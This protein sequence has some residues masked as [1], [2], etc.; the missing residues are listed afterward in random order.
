MTSPSYVNSGTFLNWTGASSASPALPA[1]RVTGNLLIA[2]FWISPGTA[3]TPWSLSGTGWNIGESY[4]GASGTNSFG[5]MWAWRYVDGTEASPTGGTGGSG[6][7]AGAIIY[8]YTNVHQTSPFG[9]LPTLPSTTFGGSGNLHALTTSTS[10]SLVVGLVGYL[11]NFTISS[12]PGGSWSLDESTHTN[13]SGYAGV[14]EVSAVYPTAGTAIGTQTISFS[15]STY[16]CSYDL[17]ILAPPPPI[18]TATIISTLKSVAQSAATTVIEPISSTIVS[19]LKHITQTFDAKEVEPGSIVST[20][21]PITQTLNA[22]EVEPGHIVSTLKPITQLAEVTLIETVYLGM[23]LRGFGPQTAEVVEVEPGSIV[24]TLRSISQTMNV[25][26]TN[27]EDVLSIVTTLLPP[28]T[29]SMDVEEILPTYIRQTLPGFGQPG[30]IVIETE[31]LDPVKIVTTLSGLRQ[32]L[33]V[34]EI[35][36]VESIVTTLPAMAAPGSLKSFIPALPG[37]FYAY[38]R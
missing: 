27:G 10:G 24:T 25:H 28:L 37:A 21:K 9:T 33:E 18:P 20:L 13:N 23:T 31:T 3:P 4:D 30:D 7:A 22:K 26:I 16:A 17:E 6:L 15:G 34:D 11:G 1:S 14:G 36:I 32:R 12:G 29:H 2:F 19:T 38:W 5:V 35:I 8:Q